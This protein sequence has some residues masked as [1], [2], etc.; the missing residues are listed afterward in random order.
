MSSAFASFPSAADYA[1]LLPMGIVA[2]TPLLILFLDLFVATSSGIRALLFGRCSC[3]T[4]EVFP[5]P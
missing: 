4:L 1:A 5:V 2:C 3:V